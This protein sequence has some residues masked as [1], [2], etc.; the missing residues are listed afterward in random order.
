MANDVRLQYLGDVIKWV[1]EA[2]A[3]ESGR[4]NDERYWD[5]RR[6]VVEA[7]DL[8]HLTFP[9]V[10]ET[11]ARGYTVTWTSGQQ[12]DLSP[13]G[14]LT[15]TDPD[16][17][18]TYTGLPGWRSLPHLIVSD[19]NSTAPWV[20]QEIS[21]IEARRRRYLQGDTS[22]TYSEDESSRGRVFAAQGNYLIVVGAIT[23]QTLTIDHFRAP[24][25]ITDQTDAAT[26]VPEMPRDGLPALG[27]QAIIDQ[28][29]AALKTTPPNNKESR[30]AL[31]GEIQRY[32]TQ[33]GSIEPRSGLLGKLAARYDIK[34]N[35]IRK[36]EAP[37][38][39]QMYADS[40]G[41]N[42]GGGLSHERVLDHW[43]GF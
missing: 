14:A 20:E 8:F 29:I 27:M 9:R 31:V 5:V 28:K 32:Q 13:A 26:F 38:Y 24:T 6:A 35:I 7:Y 25:P 12:L 2:T 37:Y 18:T 39:M 33:L 23:S 21:D 16:G 42:E 11:L 15:V 22:A 43:G 3:A 1:L 10:W 36:P 30:Q 40:Q 4:R 41:P 19:G 34:S 17:V